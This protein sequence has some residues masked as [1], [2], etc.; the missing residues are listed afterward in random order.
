LALAGRALADP[1]G[2]DDA[3]DVDG[4]ELDEAFDEETARSSL[5]AGAWMTEETLAATSG[6]VDTTSLHELEA[7]H[8]RPSPWGRLDVTVAWR[9]IDRI[10]ESSA[11]GSPSDPCERSRRHEVWLVATWRN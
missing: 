7:R 1:T 4:F 2:S 6:L 9:R 10:D 8:H 3:V 11:R 5:D